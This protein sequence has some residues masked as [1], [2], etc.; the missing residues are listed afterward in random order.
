MGRRRMLACAATAILLA[1]VA[2][3]AP[4]RTQHRDWSYYDGPGAEE[5]HQEEPPPP[6]SLPD[7]LE[8]LNRVLFDFNLGML[9]GVVAPL[10]RGWMVITTPWVRR[11]INQVGDNLQWPVRFV[12]SLLQGEGQRAAVETG[13]FVI[14]TTVGLLGF[15]DPAA[16]TGLP[17]PDPS[18]FGEVFDTWGWENQF[19]MHL[20]LR[21]PI[22]D[23]DAT[24]E[25]FDTALDPATYFFPMRGFFW[26]NEI[27]DHVDSLQRIEHVS[28]DPYE[29]VK[30]ALTLYRSHE[31]I[32]WSDVGARTPESET[33]EV[34]FFDAIDPKFLRRGSTRHARLPQPA[35]SVTYN[36]WL[37]PEPAPLVY[38]LPG[39][40]SHRLSG[41]AVGLA[42]L[43]WD[44][45]CSVVT[46]TSVFHPEFMA[47]AATT[48][49]PGYAPWDVADVRRVLDAVDADLRD[50]YA[51]RFT[52][53][54]LLGASLGGLQA[55]LLACQ[56]GGEGFDAVLAIN[57]PVSVE[58]A[59]QA[60]DRLYRAPLAWPPDERESR[61]ENLLLKV[62]HLATG[63]LEPTADLP[64]PSLQPADEM[65]FGEH[66]A[67]YLIGLSFRWTLRSAIFDSQLRD[68]LGVL[69]TR[70]DTHQR[71]PAYREIGEYGYMEYAYA[72][73]LPAVAA[74]DPDVRDGATLFERC[75]LRGVEAELAANARAQVLTNRD[76][77]LLAPDDVEF[78]QATFG[79]RLALFEEGGHMGHL[80]RPGVRL[81]ITEA[82]RQALQREAQP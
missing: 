68:P 70:L 49:L 39:L 31:V 26:F 56:P 75:S 3:C 28:E 27:T 38:V 41:Q 34:V 54:G 59:M 81:T 2:A 71:D 42:E 13:R 48:P 17:A 43:A 9:D 78:L 46:L 14:N 24:G 40:G 23:R 10:S 36:L 60:L 61:I 6:P 22:S 57:P 82:L 32:D 80:A 15:F 51:D 21:G 74:R 19:Y 30:T 67:E 77:F 16:A 1:G 52:R 44:A 20:P 50:G 18:D 25:I 35:S 72:F 4:I 29:V 7:P 37:Q 65:P 79:Q 8:P 58:H 12:A 64:L 69:L 53:R 33:L 47:Q 66:E 73:M 5:F 62:V 55:L 11:H 63:S 76:D 45:G